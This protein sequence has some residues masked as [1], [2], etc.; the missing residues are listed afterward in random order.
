MGMNAQQAMQAALA[1]QQMGYNVGSQ[2]LAA[3]LGIQQLGSG[4]NLQAQLANQQMG[5]NAQQLYEQSRQFGAGQGMNAA[6][7]SAQYGLA[8]QQA[9]EQSRQYGAGLNMQGLQ[10]ALSGAGQLGSIGQNIYGQQVGNIQ[11]QNQL[12][13][14]QQALEQAKINQQVQDYSAGQQYYMMQLANM[15]NLL[16]GLPMQ[17]TTTQTYQAPASPLSQ[18]AGAAATAYGAYK[19]FGGAAGGQPK[20]FKKRP[21]GL[22]ELALMKMQ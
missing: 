15:N 3:N 10:T 21:A 19:T 1:N 12:G 14:Q 2:N 18:G 5:L 11:L 6:Q 22:A 8:G 17:S 9:A 7:L 20:D 16:R 13:G 4:Q